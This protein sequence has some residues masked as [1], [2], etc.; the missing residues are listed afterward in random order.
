MHKIVQQL[1]LPEQPGERA[2]RIGR[3]EDLLDSLFKR[4]ELVRQ[5]A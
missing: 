1:H 5:G 2:L 3:K 4:V